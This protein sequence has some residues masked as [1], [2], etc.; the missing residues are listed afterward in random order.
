MEKVLVYE[1][2]PVQVNDLNEKIDQLGLISELKVTHVWLRTT[3]KVKKFDVKLFG[4]SIAFQ[5]FIIRAHELGMKVIIDL[6]INIDMDCTEIEYD[7]N[8]CLLRNIAT[9]WFDRYL[10]DGF[11]LHTDEMCDQ[12]TAT[13]VLKDLFSKPLGINKTKP[14][15]IIGCNDPS[16][17]YSFSILSDTP[18]DYIDDRLIKDVA[19]E[20]NPR[21]SF[22]HFMK[23]ACAYEKAIISAETYGS[24]RITEVFKITSPREVA[25]LLFVDGPKSIIL[26]QGQELG[27][28]DINSNWKNIFKNQKSDN[29]SPLSWYKFYIEKV[30]ENG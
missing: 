22:H 6:D 10:V 18:V 26:Y 24:N 5:K 1:M 28:K 30:W 8:I 19:K 2:W 20:K 21:G 9:A 13:C 27:I 11:Y 23:K 3:E 4:D 15:L 17:D 16:H 7:N 12:F 25:E 14:F 29:K